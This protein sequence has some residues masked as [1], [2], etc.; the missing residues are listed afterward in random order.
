MGV[1]QRAHAPGRQ[2]YA[3][4]GTLTSRTVVHG[5][6]VPLGRV[7]QA[8]I[9]G[10]R[11]RM[12]LG[13]HEEGHLTP[14][15]GERVW[16]PDW[17]GFERTVSPVPASKRRGTSRSA[18]LGSASWL[19]DVGRCEELAPSHVDGLDPDEKRSGARGPDVQVEN[20]VRHVRGVDDLPDT[21]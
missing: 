19:A 11:G 14:L 20:H 12:G 10:V 13:V 15:A 18:N 7:S 17:G 2:V 4:A 16:A 3:G 8:R 6:V 1:A 9:G 21:G 5:C